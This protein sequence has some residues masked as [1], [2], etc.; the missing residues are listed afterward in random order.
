MNA[1]V[2]NPGTV[3]YEQLAGKIAEEALTILEEGDF[4][5]R[6]DGL[7]T[8]HTWKF[9]FDFAFSQFSNEGDEFI[10][11]C[12][13]VIKSHAN[14]L[15]YVFNNADSFMEL[16]ST[17]LWHSIGFEDQPADDAVS[18]LSGKVMFSAALQSTRS[19]VQDA[20]NSARL[21]S[22]GVELM[23]NL[24]H[25]R[26]GLMFLGALLVGLMIWSV[27][28]FSHSIVVKRRLETEAKQA[29]E[30]EESTFRSNRRLDRAVVDAVHRVA[31]SERNSAPGS[32]IQMMPL[33][34]RHH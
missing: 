28:T 11:I 9:L 14:R 6:I 2:K 7:E 33:M 31:N 24:G 4:H 25:L 16:L 17:H 32:E 12:S 18:S 8:T 15:G 21:E 20:M 10:E 13:D 5:A 29:V 19:H 22:I 23:A 26:N 30:K 1:S 34:P 27:S 3:L